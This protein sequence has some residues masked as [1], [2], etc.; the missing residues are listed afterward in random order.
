[1]RIEERKSKKAKKGVTYRVKVDYVDEYGI[2]CTYSKSGFSS[3]AK[4]R[5]H[6]TEM[7]YKLKNGLIKKESTKTL[8]ECFLEVMELE[9]DKLAR[10]TIISYFSQYTYH[11]VPSGIASMP[12]SKVNYSVLQKFFN[13][14]DSASSLDVQKTIIKKAFKH[15]IRLGIVTFDPTSVL[16]MPK[17]DPKRKTEVITVDD[18]RAMA[19]NISASSAMVESS[20]IIG[21]YCGYYLGLRISEILAL[22]KSD[23]DFE[24]NTVFISKKV[25]SNRLKKKDSYVTDQLKT[26]KSRAV[27]PIPKELKYMLLKWFDYNPFDFVCSDQNGDIVSGAAFRSA[28]KKAAKKIGIDFHPHCLRHSY[29]TCIVQSGTD[30]KTASELARH[31]NIQTTLNIYT[32]SNIEAKQDAVSHAFDSKCPNFVPNPKYLN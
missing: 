10:N 23:F 17:Y 5:E 2:K 8:G 32:H 4:A 19:A 7:E 25:E 6:G 1:M 14:Q 28:L 22:E 9:K 13:E 12:I 20:Y 18:L 3:K 24:A 16:I 31:T 11:I 26:K 15:A 27:L 29:V 21:M 30:I